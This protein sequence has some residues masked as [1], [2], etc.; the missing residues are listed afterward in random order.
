MKQLSFRQHFKS[1]CIFILGA[2]ISLV[3]CKHSGKPLENSVEQFTGVEGWYRGNTHTHATYSDEK[4]SNDVLLIASWYEKAGYN[5]LILSEHNDHVAKKMI[6]SHDEASHPPNFIMISGLELSE[7]RHHT[8]AGINKYI[9]GETSLQD[10][11]AKTIEAGGIPILNHPQDPV[12]SAR[13]FIATKGL[14][15]LEIANGGRPEDTPATEVLWDSI[16]SAPDGRP[17][18]AVGADDN[19]YKEA[20]VGRAWIM[21][22]APKLTQSDILE[23]I[24]NGDFYATTGVILNDISFTGKK[25]IIDSRNGDTIKF[26]GKNGSVLKTVSGNKADY[27]ITGNEL[28]VRA[29][30]TDSSGKA[31]WTQPV[32][33]N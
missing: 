25:I 20:N 5:F 6:Y 9:G 29:K 21:V 24:R 10:G 23:S 22:K 33:V 28:Y 16:M 7:T 19:H 12:V 2:G 26:I 18:Y 1:V 8:A 3:S 15:H 32:F 13:A 31:A 17:V 11:V 4:D 14:N 27:E 30:I